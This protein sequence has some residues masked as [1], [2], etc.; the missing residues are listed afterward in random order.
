MGQIALAYLEYRSGDPASAIERAESALSSAAAA[1]DERQMAMAHRMLAWALPPDEAGPHIEQAAANFRRLGN[2]WHHAILYSNLAYTAVV[3]GRLEDAE[4]WLEQALP[5]TDRDHARVAATVRGNL[6]MVRLLRGHMESAATAF[7]EQLRLASEQVDP[8]TVAEGLGG[9]AALAAAEG[10]H[11]RCA[12]LFGAAR[13]FGTIADAPL[14]DE[15]ERRFYTPARAALGQAAWQNGV[16]AGAALTFRDAVEYALAERGT[17]E[18]AAKHATIA[19]AA[20]R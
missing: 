10:G 12:Q 16:D 15:L 20:R 19:A 4:A 14:L 9:L 2:R 18:V 8:G 5:L 7:T 17:N 13:R 3:Q 11:A 6:G 1:G